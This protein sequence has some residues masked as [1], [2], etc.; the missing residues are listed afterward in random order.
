YQFAYTLDGNGK[1]TQTDVTD[2]RGNVR[3][4]TFNADGQIVTDARGVGT[5]ERQDTAYEL[6]AGTN[7]LLSVTDALETSP[8]VNRKKSYTYDSMGN[9][10]RVT[11]L[12]D[13]ADAVPTTYTY[14]PTFNQV[15]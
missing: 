6:Q 1:V 12:A 7:L 14:E 4:V 10:T 5:P 8:G 11:R 2:Q 15:A 9:V 3:R 13:T